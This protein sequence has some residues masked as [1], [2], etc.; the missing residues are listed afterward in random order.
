MKCFGPIGANMF[1]I[2]AVTNGADVARAAGG[3]LANACVGH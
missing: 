3:C 1:R 2:G